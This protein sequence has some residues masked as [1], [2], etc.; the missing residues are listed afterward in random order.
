MI[1]ITYLLIIFVFIL[2]FFLKKKHD[3]A[4]LQTIAVSIGILGTF[5]GIAMG[6]S[7]FN[8]N[9]IS[10]SIPVL[11][12]G[13]KTA[14]W[15]SIAG[16]ITALIIRL[17]PGFYGIKEY[18]SSKLEEDYLQ[19]FERELPAISKS[20]SGMA[21]KQDELNKS[22]KEFAD[23]MVADN[24]QSLVN[25][26]TEVMK[27]F[28]TKI[29]E[30]FGD[31]F[32]QLNQAVEKIVEWQKLYKDQVETAIKMLE[33]SKGSLATTAQAME[34]TASSASEFKLTAQ[35]LK[36]ELGAM[37][38]FMAGIKSLAD[39]M[40]GSGESIRKEM[41]E[42]TQKNLE[43]LGRNLASISEKLA[44]DYSKVQESMSKI[45]NTPL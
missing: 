4:S 2:P 41:T 9:D 13:L 5:I 35:A 20:L 43:E 37:N 18:E 17:F 42:I 7:D 30:Q 12:A 10:V 36:E 11:L 1:T 8:I 29:N 24:S 38:S 32:K 23:R 16:S 15:T 34:I 22:F 31:N 19:S 3:S 40:S 33:A 14:F 45:V 21:D 26:L 39:S 28:N 44:N 25:A 27:D 6:L